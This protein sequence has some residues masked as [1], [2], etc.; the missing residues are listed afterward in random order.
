MDLLTVSL[1]LLAALLHAAWHSLV[2]FGQDQVTVLVG[3][4]LVGTIPAA[5]VLPFVPVPSAEVWMLLAISVALHVGY[6][7]FLAS[8]YRR[9]D[10]GQAFPMARG[11]VP[12]F[13]AGLAYGALGQLPTPLQ[14]LGIAVVAL[15]LLWLAA[16]STGGRFNL[17]LLVAAGGAGLTVAC[18]SVLD[19]YGVRIDGDWLAYTAWLI[20]IDC[21]IFALIARLFIKPDLW[22]G[23]QAMGVRVVASGIL[24]LGSFGVFLWALSRAPVGPVVALRESSVLF[25]IAIAAI[26]QREPLSIQRLLAALAIFAGIVTI[27]TDAVGPL[28]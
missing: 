25:V 12:L 24:G 26:A 9:G 21:V 28:R 17:P 3:M 7:L 6:K 16:Q 13:A 20:V 10:L 11:A 19:A 5:A 27:A 14:A 2:K 18:Y 4:G 1:M 23:V 22:R 8:A 15:G